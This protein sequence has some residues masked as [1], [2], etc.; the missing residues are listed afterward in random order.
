MVP[1]WDLSRNKLSQFP[2]HCLFQQTVN[3]IVT[4]NIYIKHQPCLD[5]LIRRLKWLVCLY[6]FTVHLWWQIRWPRRKNHD[7]MTCKRENNLSCEDK[8][9][10]SAVEKQLDCFVCIL[11]LHLVF[12]FF[13]V[14]ILCLFT[15]LY[16]FQTTNMLSNQPM[17]VVKPWQIAFDQASY[18]YMVNKF[19]LKLEWRMKTW[20]EESRT[21]P[22]L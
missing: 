6:V 11:C 18:K 5:P 19:L 1:N 8:L 14:V 10:A 13:F 12:F 7:I 3:V 22:F 16:N 17:I 21:E 2:D 20:S 15:V 4:K 9:K